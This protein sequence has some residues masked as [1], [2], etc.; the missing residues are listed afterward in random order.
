MQCF[1]GI[2]P[3]QPPQIS[4]RS[5]HK[6]LRRFSLDIPSRILQK[7]ILLQRAEITPQIAY[8]KNLFFINIPTNSFDSLLKLIPPQARFRIYPQISF[9]IPLESGHFMGIPLKNAK[10]IQLQIPTR[11]SPDISWEMT[12]KSPTEPSVFYSD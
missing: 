11:I 12:L 3:R 4:P 9:F 2:S 10:E 7:F 1:F 6:F 8:I 5:L